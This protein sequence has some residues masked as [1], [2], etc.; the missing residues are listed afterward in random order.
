[1]NSG[2]ANKLEENG[3]VKNWK[4]RS[5]GSEGKSSKGRDDRKRVQEPMHDFQGGMIAGNF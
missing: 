2:R 3:G 5:G 1:M 4:T